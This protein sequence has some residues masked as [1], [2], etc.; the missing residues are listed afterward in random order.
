MK[1]HPLADIFPLMEGEE[2]DQL[3]ADIKANGLHQDILLHEDMILDGRNRYHACL[4]AGVEPRFVRTSW[5]DNPAEAAAYV[6]SANIHRRHLTAEQ[7]REVIANLVK[8]QPEKSD[9]QIAKATGVSHPYVA[10]V[11]DEL[12]QSG[13]VETVTTSIDT[14]GRKQPKRKGWSRD[15][16]RQYRAK[17]RGSSGTAAKLAKTGSSTNKA[18]TTCD[19]GQQPNDLA[20]KLRAAEIRIVGLESEIDELK[21]EN[22]EL[23]AQLEAA[24]KVRRSDDL[25]I[26]ECLRRVAP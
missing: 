25:D 26:P 4:A 15:R 7:K 14:K 20:E 19:A 24:Q 6:I 13:D 22:A 11:R 18:I 5:M 3:V 21:R 16:Y 10:K 8:A 17:K 9:R 23:R 2:F 12:E 1:Y